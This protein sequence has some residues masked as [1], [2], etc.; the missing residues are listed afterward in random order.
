MWIHVL[1]Q[2]KP[3]VHYGK[4]FWPDAI[5]DFGDKAK[6]RGFIPYKDR[7][8]LIDLIK[9]TGKSGEIFMNNWGDRL[10]FDKQESQTSSLYEDKVKGWF[11][12]DDQDEWEQ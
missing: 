9:K 7:K 10:I 3:T 5:H 11:A 12:Q 1:K 8:A 4:L 6:G 2:Y